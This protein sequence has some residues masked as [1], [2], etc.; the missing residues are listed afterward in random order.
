MDVYYFIRRMDKLLTEKKMKEI[1][2]LMVKSRIFEEKANQLFKEK[3]IEEKP[4]SGIGQEAVSI[5]CTYSLNKEDYVIPSLRTK[6][7]FFAKGITIKEGFLELFRKEESL[8]KGL[9]T[10]HHLEDRERGILLGSAVLGSSLSIAVGAALAIKLRGT[11]QVVA[12]FFGDGASSR[13]DFHTSLNFASIH[14]LPVIF[15][16]EN[17]LYALSTPQKEQMKNPHIAHRAMGYSI[18]GE[19][20]DGQDVLE[21]YHA[22]KKAIIK[23]RK[24]EGPS[25]LEFKT[26]RFRGHTENHDCDD[27]RN[28]DELNKWRSRCP[29]RLF[30]E[31]LIKG[32]LADQRTLDTIQ[33]E[34]E[35]E[36]SLMLVE[37]ENRPNP[38]PEIMYNFLYA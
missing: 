2:R 32:G 16:C 27:G 28:R 3:R 29:I 10:F 38:S 34:I 5:G 22:T 26:Y 37:A 35:E 20:I 23:A 24:G 13:G 15:L 21:V 18:P 25:L 8:S 17:N 9:W 36:A 12:V 33:Q 6:G 19:I 30:E 7:A 1:Y 11:D 4:M 31:H 14:D